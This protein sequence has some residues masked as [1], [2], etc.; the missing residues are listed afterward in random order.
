MPLPCPLLVYSPLLSSP[1]PPSS[2]LLFSVLISCFGPVPALP[3]PQLSHPMPTP[4]L[5]YT[6]PDPLTSIQPPPP[7]LRPVPPV[8]APASAPSCPAPTSCPAPALPRP[9]PRDPR[10]APTGFASSSHRG[11]WAFRRQ[12]VPALRGNPST[13][14][15]GGRGNQGRGR[16]QP[17]PVLGSRPRPR[18]RPGSQPGCCAENTRS[19][20]TAHSALLPRAQPLW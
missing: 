13:E 20:C 16:R 5:S 3:L 2:S 7:R 14:R 19:R 17:A 11:V 6:L 18:P 4:T 1:L 10:S 9:A 12:H 15:D 8:P